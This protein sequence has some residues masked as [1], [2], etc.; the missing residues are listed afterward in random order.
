MCIWFYTYN[1]GILQPCHTLPFLLHGD[2]YEHPVK[3]VT[4]GNEPTPLAQVLS[5]CKDYL[6]AGKARKPLATT[7]Q[8]WLSNV[9]L[10][11]MEYLLQKHYVSLDLCMVVPPVLTVQL[12]PMGNASS[13]QHKL[14]SVGRQAKAPSDLFHYKTRQSHWRPQ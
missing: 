3:I 1:K 12:Q 6:S 8:N 2:I 4:Q 10:A 5:S 14:N 7:N 9:S 13:T 11:E